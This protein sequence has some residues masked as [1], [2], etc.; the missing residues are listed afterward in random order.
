MR[1]RLAAGLSVLAAAATLTG[2]G[3]SGG[4]TSATAPGNATGAAAGTAISIKN[5]MYSPASLTVKAGQAVTVTNQDSST[6]TIT[7][8]D[9]SFD[10][11]DMAQ[12]KTFTFTPSKAG[13]FTYICSIHQYMTGKIVVT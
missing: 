11:K 6:H 12:G 1:S 2:C 7:A 5:F 9:K 8:S 13:T 10:S 4:S 3:G